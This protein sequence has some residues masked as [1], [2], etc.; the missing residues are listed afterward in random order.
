[1]MDVLPIIA[2][3]QGVIARSEQY[4]QKT[5]IDTVC[6]QFLFGIS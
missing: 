2:I 3:L 5:G 1:M 6:E 4:A